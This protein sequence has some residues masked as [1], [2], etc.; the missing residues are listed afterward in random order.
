MGIKPCIDVRK[1]YLVSTFR[2]CSMLEHVRI[3]DLS[4]DVKASRSMEATPDFCLA[5]S[6]LLYQRFGQLLTS[7]TI[8][9]EN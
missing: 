2:R 7:G 3:R 1:T 6:V 9:K 8:I 5:A 4:V